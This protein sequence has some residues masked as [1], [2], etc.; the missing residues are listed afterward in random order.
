[1]GMNMRTVVITRPLEDAAALAAT[2]A[3]QGIHSLIEPMLTI[4]PLQE[5]QAALE[6]ALSRHPQA[7]L[8]TS[9]H[10]VSI[11]ARM[12][13]NRHIPVLAV[14]TAT[15]HH[16]TS[17]GF[18][19]HAAGG[20]ANALMD[21][22]LCHCT[23]EC[24]SLLYVRG[25]HISTDIANALTQKQC[26]VDSVIIY[27]A[28]PAQHFSETLHHAFRD[29]KIDAV[30]FFSQRTAATYYNLATQDNLRDLHSTATALCISKDVADTLRDL[31]WKAIHIAQKPETESLI[32]MLKK[33]KKDKQ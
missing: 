11:L 29:G 24:G 4:E 2:L 10:A 22:V 27:R 26:V 16:A 12:T 32:E 19:A 5:N 14:G 30:L 8:A 7:I 9:R 6:A 33:I 28:T 18:T 23:P 15:A 20:T 31:P 13:D 1:M 17:L 3:A 21:Y 25:D